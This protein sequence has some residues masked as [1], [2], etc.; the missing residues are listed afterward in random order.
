MS[1]NFRSGLQ[2]ENYAENV[3]IAKIPG[4][5]RN[6]C[7]PLQWAIPVHSADSILFVIT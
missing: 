4:I 7:K 6:D 2:G 5:I 3:E 1:R